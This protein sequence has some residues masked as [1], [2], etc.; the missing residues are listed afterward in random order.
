V[1]IFYATGDGEFRRSQAAFLG[2]F[3]ETDP[4]EPAEGVEDLE[5][6]LRAANRPHTFFTYPGTG[7]WFIETD[8]Q[9]SYNGPAAALAWERTVAFLH[10]SI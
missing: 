6:R 7:H 9:D 2:H 3:A 1:T 8:V 10:Q 5:R 4:F